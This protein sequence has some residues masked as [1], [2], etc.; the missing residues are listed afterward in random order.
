M[1][2]HVENKG[3]AKDREVSCSK[4]ADAIYSMIPSPCKR[5]EDDC[6]L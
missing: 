3:G 2:S 4:C 1:I 5:L 6:F